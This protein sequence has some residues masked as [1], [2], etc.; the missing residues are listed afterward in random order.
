MPY[1]WPGGVAALPSGKKI[2]SADWGSDTRCTIRIIK[3]GKI[4]TIAGDSE[5]C[6]NQ[7]GVGTNALFKGI[8]LITRNPKTG[9]ILASEYVNHQVRMIT[10]FCENEEL[11]YNATY[12][13]CI[14]VCDV[15]YYYNEETDD[16]QRI[17]VMMC[18]GIEYDNETVC[19]A[20]GSCVA[21][22]Q[23]NCTEGYSGDNCD[24]ATYQECI[25]VCD[26]G[27][28]YEV[29]SDDCQL[30]PVAPPVEPPVTN[31]TNGNDTNI[32][33]NNGD[34]STN[35]DN[36]NNG[37]NGTTPEPEVMKCNGTAYDDNNVCSAHAR[38]S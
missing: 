8:S 32:D 35:V 34:N 6:G 21:E 20:H 38:V 10:P 13:E 14:P 36:N 16:C 19:S 11:V 24:N 31:T 4:M 12:E 23:C 27:Y 37:N 26:A 28:Y 2:F 30:A 17:P 15:K 5:H 25:P 1:D 9:V 33:N 29:E 18:D 3:N 7:D 22:N